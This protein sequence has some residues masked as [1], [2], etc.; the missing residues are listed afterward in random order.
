MASTNL[1]TFFN[2]PS[3]SREYSGFR[4][5]P[6]APERVLDKDDTDNLRLERSKEGNV[7]NNKHNQYFY[8]N[9]Y[10]FHFT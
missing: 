2:N 7:V 4:N 3:T 1:Q 10:S 6:N 5:N 9:T 8:C